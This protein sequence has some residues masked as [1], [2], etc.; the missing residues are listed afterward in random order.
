MCC[1][2]VLCVLSMGHRQVSSACVQQILAKRVFFFFLANVVLKGCVVHFEVRGAAHVSSEIV[3]VMLV[4]I[5][6]YQGFCGASFDTRSAVL[7]AIVSDVKVCVG[8][9]CD[10]C[11]ASV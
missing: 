7:R 10:R 9:S 1:E 8:W 4:F 3:K 5:V 6:L 11:S 2:C